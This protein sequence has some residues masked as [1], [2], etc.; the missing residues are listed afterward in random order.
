[1]TSN[2]FTE[3]IGLRS[4][5]EG[6]VDL[7]F[8][9]VRCLI[10][11]NRALQG[12]NSAM[13]LLVSYFSQKELELFYKGCVC[14]CG[15]FQFFLLGRC[16]NWNSELDSSLLF[17]IPKQLVCSCFHLNHY[18]NCTPCCVLCIYTDVVKSKIFQR[19]RSRGVLELMCKINTQPTSNFSVDAFVLLFKKWALFFFQEK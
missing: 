1:M 9:E 5:K 19:I 4:N 2:V 7:N 14:L 6:M 8:R 11:M 16:Y 18:K 3:H 10:L 17:Y 13:L 15:V 12:K